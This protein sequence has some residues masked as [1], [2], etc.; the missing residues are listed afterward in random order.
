MAPYLDTITVRL[1]V[2]ENFI[3]FIF[4]AK[5]TLT[6]PAPSSVLRRGSHH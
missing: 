4:V 2:F 3:E 6:A 5:L 1:I